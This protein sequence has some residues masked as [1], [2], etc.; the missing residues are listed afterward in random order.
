MDL[1]HSRH[2]QMNNS[3]DILIVPSK[4]APIA[5]ESFGTLIVNPGLLSKGANGGTYA[6]VTIAPMSPK[7][8]GNES[9]NLPHNIP[10]RS[11]VQVL[12]I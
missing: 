3:P 11:K 1:R 5:A 12:K 7:D 4:L 10:S 8:I 6:S 2:W 9:K